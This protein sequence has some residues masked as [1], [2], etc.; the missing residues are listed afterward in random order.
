MNVVSYLRVSGATQVEGDGL[1][2]QAKAIIDF[3]KANGLNLCSEFSERG[4]S[5]TTEGIDRPAFSLALARMNPHNPELEGPPCSAIVVERMDRL[6]RDLMVSELLLKECRTRGIK[7]FSADQGNLTDMA[8]DGGDPTRVLIRQIMGALAEW[9][10]SVLVRKL[11][12][13]KDRLKAAG[14]MNV[15]GVKPYGFFKPE[16]ALLKL[17]LD[18][19][20]GEPGR[21]DD[22]ADHPKNYREISRLLNIMDSRTRSGKH[23]TEQNVRTIILN[24]KR[25]QQSNPL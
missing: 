22:H 17:M 2:R 1:E 14:K 12:S 15:E 3:C 11:R 9:E 23:W 6:A 4:V 7:V 18:W 13:A 24:A 5:G 21:D 16:A 19:H 25:K 20:N 8:A 10:K